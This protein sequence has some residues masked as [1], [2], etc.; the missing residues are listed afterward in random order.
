MLP[1]VCHS[2]VVLFLLR[3]DPMT[4]VTEQ[5]VLER[6]KTESEIVKNSD[7]EKVVR[8]NI[9]A[10]CDK[11]DSLLGVDYCA[12]CK[13]ILIFKTAFRYARCPLNKWESSIPPWI[14]G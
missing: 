8:Q 5:E 9:C 3:G 11:K 1:V 14:K 12:E 6:L 13:C 2:V 4:Q 10:S 7:V